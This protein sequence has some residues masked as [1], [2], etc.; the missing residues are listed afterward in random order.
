MESSEQPGAIFNP[1]AQFLIILVCISQ[2]GVCRYLERWQISPYVW[3]GWF[4]LFRSFLLYMMILNLKF[5]CYVNEFLLKPFWMKLSWGTPVVLR[6]PR[7][8]WIG[9]PGRLSCPGCPVLA[10]MSWLSCP[11]CPVLAVLSLLSC[12]GCPVSAVPS[13]FS[14]PQL[15]FSCYPACSLM[16]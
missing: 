16:F 1:S 4:L 12:P 8:S 15:S 13:Q 10:V 14:C 6:R 7:L 9:W 5:I 11:D 2:V 3:K